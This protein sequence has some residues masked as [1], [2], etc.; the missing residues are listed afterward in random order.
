ML[1]IL[2]VPM[3]SCHV[4][5]TL[6]LR[7]FAAFCCAILHI[8]YSSLLDLLPN[9]RLLHRFRDHNQMDSIPTHIHLSPRQ[10]CSIVATGVLTATVTMMHQAQLQ[11]SS[12]AGLR[13]AH[14]VEHGAHA[15]QC[16]GTLPHRAGF[17][18]G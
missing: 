13:N 17:P 14:I 6:E 8:A 10:R 1:R 4:R 16:I 5:G 11:V 3:L 12:L 9:H 18:L 15:A 7:C 2:H